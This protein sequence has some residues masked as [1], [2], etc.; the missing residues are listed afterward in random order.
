MANTSGPQA[1][2]GNGQTMNYDAARYWNAMVAEIYI[3]TG[4]SIVPTEGTRTWSR[5]N[6]LYQLYRAGR[7][8]P[9]WSPN[10]ARAYHLSGRA[11]DVGSSVGFVNTNNARVF[12]AYAGMYGFR[13]TVH[14]E[15]WHFEWR[16]DWV[17]INLAAKE[18]ELMALTDAEIGRIMNFAA[19]DK[20]PSFSQ[21]L[22]DL[23]LGA[24]PVVIRNGKV[25]KLQDDADTNTMVRGL[26]KSIA[27]LQ[28]EIVS[29]KGGK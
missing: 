27:D 2:I 24:A 16:S 17:T 4:I 6:E 20:G 14:G 26:V 19:Y 22:K 28:A 29:L 1:S 10:D 9:A 25:T 11:V 13:E 8:N 15:P 5:Q 3:K 21:V 18:L 7:G 12:R 23:H